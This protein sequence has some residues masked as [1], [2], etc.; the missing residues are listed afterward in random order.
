MYFRGLHD[1]YT[2]FTSKTYMQI[3]THLY[4]NYGIITAIDIMENE[5]RMDAPYDSSVAIESYLDQIEDTAEFAEAGNSPFSTLRGLAPRFEMLDN[6]C[7][8]ELIRVMTKKIQLEPQRLHQSNT[9]ER[10]I[11][12]WKDHFIA[13]LC[14][15]DPCFP[16][17]L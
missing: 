13:I 1:R 7:S 3:I 8:G 6:E 12:M 9:A 4:T 15:I 2:G 5:K 11:R 16:L 17:Q 14:G 10:E